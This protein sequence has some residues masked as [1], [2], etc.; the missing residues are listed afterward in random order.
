MK[1]NKIKWVSVDNYFNKFF[2]V[3]RRITKS[4]VDE[5]DADVV[6]LPF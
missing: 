1:V 6:N 3:R 5:R 2:W 4:V